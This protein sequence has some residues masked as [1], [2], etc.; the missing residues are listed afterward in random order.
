MLEGNTNE[1]IGQW[2]LKYRL[3]LV[4]VGMPILFFHI[5]LHKAYGYKPS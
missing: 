3:I 2:E 5:G 4:F 1:I